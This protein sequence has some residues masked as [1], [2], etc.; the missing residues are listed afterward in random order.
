[1]TTTLEGTPGPVPAGNVRRAADAA[2]VSEV[3]S[4]FRAATFK[5]YGRE[6]VKP[7][8]VHEFPLTVVAQ[9]P[10][11]GVEYG[12]TRSPEMVMS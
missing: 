10:D 5:K 6:G 12:P 11:S 7:S 1:M 3:P 2:E 8:I 9:D 4:A